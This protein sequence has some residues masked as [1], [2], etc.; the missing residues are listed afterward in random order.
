MRGPI[1]AVG[2]LVVSETNPCYFTVAPGTD[3]GRVAIYLT[4]SHI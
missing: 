1:A 3:A 2:P 4:G